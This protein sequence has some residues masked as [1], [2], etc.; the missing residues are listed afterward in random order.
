MP[1]LNSF[2]QRSGAWEAEIA[3][4]A[5]FPASSSDQKLVVSSTCTLF[6]AFPNS[7]QYVWWTAS[8]GVFSVRFG[9]NAPSATCGMHM[10]P[11]EYL[12]SSSMA[13]CAKFIRVG[14][15]DASRVAI[16]LV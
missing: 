16:P 7:T 11:G 13:A 5:Q 14:T 15:I 6:A 1:N 10:D 3:P 9:T 4:L 8:G 12:W 2:V